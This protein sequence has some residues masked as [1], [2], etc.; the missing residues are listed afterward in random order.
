MTLGCA[1]FLV[2][3]IFSVLFG[4]GAPRMFGINS[5]E[6]GIWIWAHQFWLNF[7]GSFVGW[8][9]LWLLGVRVHVW[10]ASDYATPLG[11]WEV[12]LFA[13]AF[14]G[15]TG[16]LPMASVTLIQNL[17]NWVRKVSNGEK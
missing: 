15:V 8:L 6:W 2:A 14:I 1:F 11:A 5:K 17:S 4:I 3:I 9:C 10:A 13:V 7:L 16:F 12:F